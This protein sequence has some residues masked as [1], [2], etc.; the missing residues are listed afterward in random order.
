[1]LTNVL[2]LPKNAKL[3]SLLHHFPKLNT[4]LNNIS[5]KVNTVYLPHAYC[6]AKS[7]LLHINDADRDTMTTV[8]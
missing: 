1:M 7:E 8:N 4:S 6:T 2:L 3:H 5:I